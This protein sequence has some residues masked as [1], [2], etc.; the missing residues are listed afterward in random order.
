[1]YSD[2]QTSATRRNALANRANRADRAIT[3]PPILR[4]IPTRDRTFSPVPMATP[5][6]DHAHAILLGMRNKLQDLPEDNKIEAEGW[7]HRFSN[8]LVR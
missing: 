3:Y 5:F 4:T 7:V 6:Y 2:K 8:C 1:M